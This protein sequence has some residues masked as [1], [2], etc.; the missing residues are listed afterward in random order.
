MFLEPV[1]TPQ[2]LCKDSRD[3]MATLPGCHKDATGTLQTL[4]GDCANTDASGNLVG[5]CTAAAW[6]L[7]GLCRDSDSLDIQQGLNWEPTRTQRIR[8]E[9][10]IDAMR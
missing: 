9:L 3:S 8:W 4:C 2:G 5:F 6:N 10:T 1:R 7:E